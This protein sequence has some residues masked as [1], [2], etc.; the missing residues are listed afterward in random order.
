MSEGK[1][2]TW[3][4]VT[5]SPMLR[6]RYHASYDYGTAKLHEWYTLQI[7]RFTLFRKREKWVAVKEDNWDG[8]G[9][10]ARP[11]SGDYDW[12]VRIAKDFDI[13]LPVPTHRLSKIKGGEEL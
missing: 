8:L 12:A 13:E 5:M 4:R 11:V 7:K 9:V 3:Y 2:S 6:L 1:T 10:S